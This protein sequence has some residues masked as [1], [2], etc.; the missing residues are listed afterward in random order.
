MFKSFFLLSLIAAQPLVAE[1]KVLLFA[2]SLRKDSYNKQ[3][4]QE[5]AKVVKELQGIPVV[6]DLKEYQMPFY[7]EDLER[8][9]GMPENAKKL[10]SLMM[11]SSVIVIASPEYN[12]SIPGVLK[13]ALDWASRS[14]SS[15]A[16]RSAFKGKKF[17]LL[18]ASP[19]SSG[20][21]RGL[22]HLRG[23]IEDIGGKVLMQQFSLPKAYDAFDDKGALKDP[24]S[25]SQLRKL[26]QEAIQ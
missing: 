16:S 20:G 18:S 19:G 2:G 14:E 26:L 23:I 15:G 1:T 5:A 24:A 13:N 25:E 11:Q 8:E 21:K 9:A 4:I 7:D 10:R 12:S 17:V 3:L 6:I 22:V